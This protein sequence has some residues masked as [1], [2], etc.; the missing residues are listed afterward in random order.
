MWG[1]IFTDGADR[2]DSWSQVNLQLTLNAPDERWYVQA[3]VK[4]LTE[5]DG[6]T[7]EYLTS[8]TSALYTNAFLVD[9]RTYGARIGARF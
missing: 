4:N 6:I 9:P 1:R 2:I 7:G 3:F 5:S 8:S